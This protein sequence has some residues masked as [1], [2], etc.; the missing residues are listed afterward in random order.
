MDFNFF[1]NDIFC[2]NLNMNHNKIVLKKKIKIFS[3]TF[4]RTFQEYFSK[5]SH[6]NNWKVGGCGLCYP[7]YTQNYDNICLIC[8]LKIEQME[9]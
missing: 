6:K 3:K 1:E 7:I 8:R 4:S 5:N 2:K 9:Q